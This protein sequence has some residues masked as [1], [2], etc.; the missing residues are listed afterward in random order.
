MMIR[1]E[2][3]GDEPGIDALITDSFAGAPHSSGTEA[4]IVSALRVAGA[5]MSSLV[6]VQ[7]EEIVGHVAISPVSIADSQGQWFGLGP[8]A[9]RPACQRRGI[10]EALIDEALR[11]L[12]AS[13]AAG[14]VV[15]GEPD[16]YRRFGFRHDPE[17]T[18]AGPPPA[19]FQVLPF[20]DGRARGAVTYHKAFA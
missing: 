10:G 3:P 13:G 18:F 12:R 19:Y 11:K 6:A 9:V 17:V 15:L 7:G 2:R 16:Y 5:L 4:A 1:D 14:C 8:V 20:G